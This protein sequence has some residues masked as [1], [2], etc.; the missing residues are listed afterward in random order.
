MHTNDTSCL[1]VDGKQNTSKSRLTPH[2]SDPRFASKQCRQIMW[3]LDHDVVLVQPHVAGA[4]GFSLDEMMQGL[5][6]GKQEFAAMEFGSCA[7]LGFALAIVGLFSVMT[8]IVSLKSHDIGIRF[9]LGAPPGSILRMMLKQG[10]VLIVTGI[11][12]G[13]LASVGTTR[14]LSALFRGVSATDPLTLI[15]VVV[16]ILLAGLSACFLP[17][18]RDG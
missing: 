17:A 14:Y 2:Y 7:L 3:S 4:T 16:I 9:A 6:Y 10:L 8:Y 11:V 12:I 5:V 18:R 15:L 1:V 13:L